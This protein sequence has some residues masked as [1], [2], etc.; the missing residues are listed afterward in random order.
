M[1][2]F[3]RGKQHSIDESTKF[4]YEFLKWRDANGVDR[5]RNDI[6][7]GGIDTPLKFPKG[8]II[9]DIAPQIILSPNALDRKGRPLALERY[10]FS[11]AEV[12]KNITIEDYL[13]FLIYSLEYR[14]II[15]E[16]MSHER[17]I[18]YLAAHPNE[19]DRADGYGVILLDFTIRDLKGTP[20]ISMA[21]NRTN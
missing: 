3:I 18:A 7:Y 15:L 10:C 11:P 13:L 1:L 20:I 14:S 9:I 4:I 5:I 12:F 19:E 16:Q 21:S 6:I 17:E 8:Q 2:R